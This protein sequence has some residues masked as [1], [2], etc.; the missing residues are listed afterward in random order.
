[1]R[2]L[3]PVLCLACVAVVCRPAPPG[4]TSELRIDGGGDFDTAESHSTRMCVSPNG[5]TFVLWIDDRDG[6]PDLW[7]NRKLAHP[8]RDQGWLPAP[9][10][11]NS[12]AGSTV[13]RPDL[14][15]TDEAVYVVWEDDRDGEIEAHQVY[16]QRSVD[17]GQTWL[18][19][20][21]L[22]ED[23]IDGRSDS[24][25]P[26][27]VAVGPNVYVTWSDNLDGAFDIYF[28]R[29]TDS[30]NTFQRP[31]RVD[32]DVP[33]G[34][35]YSAFPRLAT[36]HGGDHVYVT[37][38]DFRNGGARG[39]AGTDI[40]FARSTDKG[41]SFQPDVRI[42]LGD[43][44][45]AHDSFVPQIAADD[46]HVTIVWHDNRSGDAN[47]VLMAYSGNA[48]ITWSTSSRADQGD[49]PGASQSVY[50]RLCVVGDVAHIVWTD[51][52][53]SGFARAYYNR[54]VAGIWQGPEFRLDPQKAPG[55]RGSH[56]LS[57]A[58]N[59]SNVL[60]GWLDDQNDLLDL[61]LNAIAYDFSADGGR[62][63]LEANRNPEDRSTYRLDS[64]DD[65]ASQK[66]EVAL[67]LQ[68]NQVRA[69][70]TDGRGR[71]NDVYFQQLI[72]GEAP[73][74]LVPPLE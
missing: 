54:A 58:C 55:T 33:V 56:D 4:E 34:G 53:D 52:R 63:W 23:D 6:T 8:D 13:W 17:Q 12:F 21:V 42:D 73:V 43:E 22:L 45:G 41:Q 59:G 28:A 39:D 64:L 70:W 24:F 9:V 10:R 74:V 20:D 49:A 30:G 3:G 67:S 66:S 37:W 18:P 35:A 72:A 11:V 38:Q 16:F 27:V 60:V 1:M 29:S 25:D 26:D 40:Y 15:C 65:G 5:T 36:G 46:D 19:A 51:D 14:A 31:L 50:P 32:S 7:M 61:G 71:S 68:G 2:N 62:T 57:I 47:D 69:A 48:G 44:P